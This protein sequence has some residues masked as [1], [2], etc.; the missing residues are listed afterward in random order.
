MSADESVRAAPRR[1][2]ETRSSSLDST[3]D[4]RSGA[5][6]ATRPRSSSHDENENDELFIQQGTT[7]IEKKKKIMMM[8]DG[9]TRDFIAENIAR[10]R[11]GKRM[12]VEKKN[13][14]N[15]AS[16]LSKSSWEVTNSNFHDAIS[17]CLSMNEA[18]HREDGLC[19]K[20]IFGAMP[21]WDTRLVT[22]MV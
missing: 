22:N 8:T 20:G 18:S 17:E 16:S 7:K 21:D 11:E 15:F 5:Q 10:K 13:E 14:E 9:E 3:F 1:Q 12:M 4:E 2:L 6:N 19:E